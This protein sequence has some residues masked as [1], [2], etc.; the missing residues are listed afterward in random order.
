MPIVSITRLRV[1]SWI[2]L[3]AFFLRALRIGGQA[4]SAPGNLA[5]KILN[6]RRHTFWTCTSWE[7]EDAMRSFMLAPPHGP[8][9]R[10][11]LQWCDEASL[12]HWSQPG[13]ELP[14]W[15]EAH[16]RLQCSGRRSKVNHPS[17]D[18]NRYVIAPPRSDGSGEVRLK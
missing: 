9:M 16:K 18:H 8:A 14:T 4:K 13:Q 15:T 12:V 1:R 2:F 7:S 17:E 11:L 3:P 5:V 6:D 10:R